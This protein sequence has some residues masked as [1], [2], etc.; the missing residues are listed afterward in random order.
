M[1]QSA[2]KVT[3]TLPLL[4]SDLDEMFQSRNLTQAIRRLA[5]IS[6]EE[7]KAIYGKYQALAL[8]RTSLLPSEQDLE[9]LRRPVILLHAAETAASI[10]EADQDTGSYMLRNAM[11]MLYELLLT[12]GGPQN[13]ERRDGWLWGPTGPPKRGLNPKN[14]T[15]EQVYALHAKALGGL[16]ND[17]ARAAFEKLNAETYKQL[18]KQNIDALTGMEDVSGA[19]VNA[20]LEH[21]QL[22]SEVTV[23]MGRS[24]SRSETQRVRTHSE[25]AWELT[26]TIKAATFNTLRAAFCASIESALRTIPY[27]ESRAWHIIQSVGTTEGLIRHWEAKAPIQSAMNTSTYWKLKP[28]LPCD[29]WLAA[30]TAARIHFGLTHDGLTGAAMSLMDRSG[31]NEAEE[32]ALRSTTRRLQAVPS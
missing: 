12:L 17:D 23:L 1:K 16:W 21:Q 13:I 19:L 8:A 3:P 28:P 31:L 11:A 29:F 24:V 14:A 4:W 27:V 2:V 25:R 10:A 5:P 20:Y 7:C 15:S 22:R 32:K 6:E 30:S 18:M 9:D 26:E